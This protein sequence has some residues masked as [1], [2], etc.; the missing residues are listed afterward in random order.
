MN[1]ANRKWTP[2]FVWIAVGAAALAG[3]ALVIYATRYG[4]GVGGDATIYLTTAR[5]LLAGVGLG[6]VEADGSFRVLPYTPPGY[7]LALSAL[8]LLFP[9]LTAGAR[10]LNVVV[11]GA[12]VL[13]AGWFFYRQTGRAWLAGLLALALAGSPVLLGVTVWAMS[14]PLFLL[15]GFAGLALL[16][17]YFERRQRAALVGSAALVGLAF[18]TRYMGVA[19]VAAGGLALLAFAWWNAPREGRLHKRLAGPSWRGLGLYGLIALLPMGAWVVIDLTLTG[20]VSSRSGQDAADWARRFAEFGPALERIYLFWLLPE[21]VAARLPGTARAALW[22][23]PLAGL[24]AVGAWAARGGLKSPAQ[25]RAARLA[26]LMAAFAVLYLAALAFVQVFTYPPVTLAGRMLSPVHLAVVVGLFALGSL[27]LERIAEEPA[28]LEARLERLRRLGVMVIIY[29]AALGLAGSYALR[30]FLVAREYHRT[31][32]GYTA[33]AWQTSD[34][35]AAARALPPE[36]PLISND[37]TALMYLADRP[38]Y[39]LQEIFQQ[40]PQ[41]TFTVYGQG[42]DESQRVFREEGGALVLF[43]DTLREDFGMYGD[44]VDER[45]AV[46]TQGLVVYF[47]GEDGAIYFYPR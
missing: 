36:V 5:N 33:P 27:V 21:S 30:G 9:D 45:L 19:F 13:G 3:M 35:L 7:P 32:I 40:R 6:W 28:R 8:G 38:A 24:A 25:A 44:R 20:A 11:F 14:E 1:A 16:L 43:Y 41:K 10:M 15:L 23:V 31:G 29:A 17:K 46:L 42:E 22:L 4:P 26:A 34:V 47:Q 39:T 37:V 2:L 12:T 18:L